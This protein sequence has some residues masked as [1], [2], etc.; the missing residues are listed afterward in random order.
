MYLISESNVVLH[1]EKN[2]YTLWKKNMHFFVW[3]ISHTDH[4]IG[5]ISWATKENVK[6]VIIIWEKL[7]IW[8]KD[9]RIWKFYIKF[10]HFGQKNKNTKKTSKDIIVNKISIC[11]VSIVTMNYDNTK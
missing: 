7:E 10:L 1:F 2:I 9:T 11:S 5:L 8:K 6:H 4:R 3:K